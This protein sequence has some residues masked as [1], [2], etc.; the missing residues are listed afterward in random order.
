[1][2]ARVRRSWC[3]NGEATRSSGTSYSWETVMSHPSHIEHLAEARAAGYEVVLAYVCIDDPE[4]NVDRVQERVEDGGHP[5][6]EESSLPS[7]HE[8][9]PSK[10]LRLASLSQL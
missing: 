9:R 6:R 10:H 5:V 2:P 1:M 3:A 7:P 8:P 4:V